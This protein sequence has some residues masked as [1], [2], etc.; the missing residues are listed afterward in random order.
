MP[1]NMPG[2]QLIAGI[3]GYLNIISPFNGNMTRL[4][5]ASWQIRRRRKMFRRGHSGSVGGAILSRITALDWTASLKI[6]WDIGNPPEDLLM[7]DWGCGIQFGM[8]SFAAWQAYGIAQQGFYLAPSALLSSFDVDDSSEGN[9]DDI[10]TAT[11]EVVGNALLFYLPDQLAQYN[12]W[13][14]QVTALG[15]FNGLANFTVMQ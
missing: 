14:Q 4:D 2:G 10:V 15:Q 12:A 9:D 7:S 3:G 1:T 11:A 5:A 8:G 13:L 6:W